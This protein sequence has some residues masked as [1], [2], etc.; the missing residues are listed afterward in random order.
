MHT[1]ESTSA[2]ELERVIAEHLP[3]QDELEFELGD[4]LDIK[5]SIVL[6]VIVFLADQS[7]KFLEAP[8]PV[9]WHVVQSFA[10]V[11]L[12]LSGV[13]S[14]W[15]LIPR[16]YKTRMG[17]DEFL[18]WVEQLRTFYNHEGVANP[19]TKIAE[20]IR[21]KD[22]QRTRERIVAN[23][24]INARKSSAMAW[25]FYSVMVAVA[26]NLATLFALSCRWMF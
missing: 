20:I 22:A 6:V 16:E 2:K 5:M 12:I 3:E 18:S 24:A 1:S 21:V 8:M 19:E 13:L 7:R 14:L 10:V 23:K 25:A 4:T 11:V 9:H 17:H 15:E 26:L